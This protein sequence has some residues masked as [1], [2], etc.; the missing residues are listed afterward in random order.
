[1]KQDNESVPAELLLLRQ[2]TRSRQAPA[3]LERTLRKEFRA[4]RKSPPFR[5]NL[6][7]QWSVAAATAIVLAFVMLSPQPEAPE[8]AA[9]TARRITTDFLPVGY[10]FQLDPDE[11]AQI[12]RI[13]VPRAEMVRF[14]LPVS[15]ESG[16]ERVSADVVL[17]ED[18]I[19]RAIRFVE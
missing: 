4:R 1:M 7:F 2:A 17:G 15:L 10:G 9:G 11:F 19:A 6:W 12:I 18:G 13:R 3:R 14:G 8:P 5:Q 16:P